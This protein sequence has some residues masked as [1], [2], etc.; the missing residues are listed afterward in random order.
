MQVLRFELRVL[1]LGFRVQV[2]AV[3]RFRYFGLRAFAR[4]LSP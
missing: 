3:S 2:L 1:A 4:A